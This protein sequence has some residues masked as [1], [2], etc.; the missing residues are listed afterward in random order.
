MKSFVVYTEWKSIFQLLPTDE[1]RTE[2]LYLIFDYM[3]GEPLPDCSDSVR[4]AW[5]YLFPKLEENK[6][7]W[8]DE[9]Q[10]RSEAGRLGGLASGEARRSNRSKCLKQ[11]EAI[12]QSAS[13]C[14]NENEANEAVNVNV[15]VND[16]VNV[17]DNTRKLVLSNV[18]ENTKENTKEKRFVKPTLDEIQ[19]YILDNDLNVDAET[20][21]DFYESK[22]W[23]VGKSPMKDWRAALRNWNRRNT[24]TNNGDFIA[25]FEKGEI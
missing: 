16:N 11:D 6:S 19:L 21:F 1:A 7:K 9:R 24:R 13:I 25:A 8:E 22:S 17:L 14:L 10:K 5:E 4:I 15:N 20:F 12:V 18:K 23:K 3:S 2:L